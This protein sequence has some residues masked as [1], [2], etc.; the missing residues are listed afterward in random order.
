MLQNKSSRLL[1]VS[2]EYIVDTVY[3]NVSEIL[4]VS[5]DFLITIEFVT[6]FC[7]DHLAK[8][9]MIIVRASGR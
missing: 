4:V 2:M 3:Y 1:M 8:I 7:Q 6:R 5:L 9:S